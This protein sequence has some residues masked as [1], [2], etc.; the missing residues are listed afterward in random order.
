MMNKNKWIIF[1]KRFF[2]FG[3]FA[4]Y[5]MVG[6]CTAAMLTIILHEPV[7]SNLLVFACMAWWAFHANFYITFCTYFDKTGH[8]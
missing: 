1:F 4:F 5:F 3:F 8:L 6:L 2:N 7:V